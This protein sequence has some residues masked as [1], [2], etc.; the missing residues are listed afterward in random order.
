[1]ISPV[2]DFKL[3]IP[4]DSKGI[5]HG[6]GAT[7]WRELD[8]R[9]LSQRLIKPNMVVCDVGANVGYYVAMYGKLMEDS[10]FI[11]ALEPDPRSITY[12]RRNVELNGLTPRVHI[13]AIALS[14]HDGELPFHLANF[15]NLSGLQPS[16]LSR[17][18]AETVNV[19]VRDLGRYLGS[20]PHKIDLLR[21]DIEGHEV[22]ILGS[23]ANR[24]E[25]E[26]SVEWAP[27]HIIFEGHAW[28]YSKS[29]D[30]SM[31]PVVERLF[32]FGYR[33]RYLCTA[34]EH[35][36]PIRSRGYTPEVV[37]DA[38]RRLYGVYEDVKN[39]DALE[40]ISEEPGITTICL[41]RDSS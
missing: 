37:I 16:T 7:G 21:M 31:R 19:P 2:Y 38:K 22:Q 17:G 3:H 33:A 4:L 13:D 11:Y 9:Y 5:E 41:G 18:Y 40:L 10:G 26:G 20:L 34:M 29:G 32:R 36:S 35:F 28:E 14:D 23:L 12:L 24:A 1:M 15:P 8:H 25:E 6:L 30:N 39:A 27:V